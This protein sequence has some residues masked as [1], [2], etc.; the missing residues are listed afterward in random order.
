M[1]SPRQNFEH[2]APGPVAIDVVHGSGLTSSCRS[3]RCFRWNDECA[4]S[5]KM[6]IP[7]RVLDTLADGAETRRRWLAGGQ[8]IGLDKLLAMLPASAKVEQ[9]AMRSPP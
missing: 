7:R 3:H 1:L 9:G 2:A 6:E 8:L 4:W 5:E